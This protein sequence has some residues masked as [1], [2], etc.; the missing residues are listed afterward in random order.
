[1]YRIGKF[2][3]VLCLVFVVSASS[4]KSIVVAL[5][6]E[7]M[8]IFNSFAESFTAT[9]DT[10]VYLVAQN[11]VI[12]Q[13]RLTDGT[14]IDVIISDKPQYLQALKASGL[15]T[16]K[17]TIEI[18]DTLVLMSSRRVNKNTLATQSP[19]MVFSKTVSSKT[20]FIT[21]KNL[22]ILHDILGRYVGIESVNF[23]IKT[24]TK[25]VIQNCLSHIDSLCIVSFFES[26]SYEDL[27]TIYSIPTHDFK[28]DYITYSGKIIVGTNYKE[29]QKFFEYI[30]KILTRSKKGSETQ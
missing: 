5:P 14:K 29:S 24:T 4:V 8:P 12:N 30:N 9:S 28:Y 25:D 13:T 6:T 1:M 21:Q 26:S 15:V 10:Q 2:L 22:T 20:V 18:K 11:E 7:L 19:V 23:I 27:S 17:D 16:Q 3:A